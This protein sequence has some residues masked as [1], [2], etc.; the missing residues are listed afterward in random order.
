LPLLDT[1]P[2]RGDPC[3]LDETSRG[4]YREFAGRDTIMT[5]RKH[6]KAR[7]IPLHPAVREIFKR[8]RAAFITTCGRDPGP[9]DPVFCDPD[10][11]TPQR[12]S[13]EV[14]MRQMVSAMET[15]GLD[16]LLIHAYQRTGLLPT[17][18]TLQSLS[19]H[20]LADWNAACKEYRKLQRRKHLRKI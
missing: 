1:I 3:P 10:A 17:A 18:N 2:R 19:T 14:L 7:W 8:R 4:I 15:A 13:E 5:R 6:G 20:D 11:D 12:L 9:G 16:P